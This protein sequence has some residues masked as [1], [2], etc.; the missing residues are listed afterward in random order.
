MGKTKRDDSETTKVGSTPVAQKQ[1][2]ARSGWDVEPRSENKGF[3]ARLLTPRRESEPVGVSSPT[4]DEENDKE[5]LAWAESGEQDALFAQIAVLLDK[6]SS[7]PV[8]KKITRLKKRVTNIETDTHYNVEAAVDAAVSA[9]MGK[10]GHKLDKMQQQ[11]LFFSSC[12]LF[13]WLS[14]YGKIGWRMLLCGAAYVILRSHIGS[15]PVLGLGSCFGSD[16]SAAG[17]HLLCRGALTSSLQ[18]GGVGGSAVRRKT[19]I[20]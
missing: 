16:Q 17:Q 15:R 19:Q 13:V 8:T 5:T 14:F 12:L 9:S 18:P 1:K 3:F 4:S 20:L 2:K 11:L 10:A 7:N 6:K